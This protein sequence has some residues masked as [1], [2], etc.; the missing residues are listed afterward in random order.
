MS[1]R[2]TGVAVSYDEH[3][4]VARAMPATGKRFATTQTHWFR[5]RDGLVV[6]HWA[7]RDD[8]GMA[9]QLGWVPPTPQFLLEAAVATRRARKHA[10]RFGG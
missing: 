2:Q 6:E 10:E 5:L 1:G 3:G 4:R 8:Q 7:N 9:M